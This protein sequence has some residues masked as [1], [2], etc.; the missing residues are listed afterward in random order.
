MVKGCVVSMLAVA[1]VMTAG[2]T[3]QAASAPPLTGP[4]QFAMAVTML[5]NPDRISLDGGSQSL[6]TVQ[7]RG[8]NGQVEVNVPLHLDMLPNGV[9]PAYDYGKL[10]ASNIVTGTDGN[11]FAVYTAPALAAG[12]NQTVNTVSIRAIIVGTDAVAP[13]TYTAVISLVPIGVILPPSVPPTPNFT[14]A[15]TPVNVNVPV[16]FDASSSCPGS[17]VTPVTNPPVCLSSSSTV[18]TNYA[19]DFGDGATGFGRTVSHTYTTARTFSVTLTITND[20]GV[21]ASTTQQI[22]PVVTAPPSPSFT[23]SPGTI[24]ANEPVFFVSTTIVPPGRTYSYDWDFGD[25]TT[26]GTGAATTHTY[27][28]GG[29]VI[30]PNT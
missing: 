8:P 2:C 22:S 5:A 6:V 29:G 28:G 20:R 25:N 18:I 4:S 3:H 14:W 23:V 24:H 19:W 16:T 17:A 13:I 26:H 1:A 10:N 30:L 11:A 12:T 7:V 9:F 27:T 15:P 21:S